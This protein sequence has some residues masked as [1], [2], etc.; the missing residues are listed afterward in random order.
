[1]EPIIEC[2]EVRR[3]FSSRTFTG[4]KRETVALDNL[5]FQVPQ[6]IVFSLLGPN[7]AGKTTTI[8]MLSTLLIPNSGKVTV[9]GFDIVKE[10]SKVRRRIGLIL[11]GERG[12]YGRLNGRENLRYFA[13]LNHLGSKQARKRVDE[14]LDL[15][16]LTSASDRPVE[17]YSRG[18]RQR[19]HVARGLLAD[20]EILFM[21]EPTLG[22]DPMGAQELRLMIPELIHQGKTILLTTHYMSEADDLSD[23]IAIINEEK[24]IASGI[25]SDIKRRFSKIGVQEVILR[26]IGLAAV[27]NLTQIPG[28]ERVTSSYD[29]PIQKLTVHIKPGAE[30]M[31][32]VTAML[33]KDNIESMVTRDPTLEEAY[34]SIFKS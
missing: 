12:L 11:G 25:P 6:G 22:L 27:E 8:K 5:S 20:P 7:G 3:V 32:E 29:G 9:A 24:I 2:S 33:G 23:Q 18:M 17:Q 13:A 26:Q 30:V 14:L 28:I 21:D 10:A 34:L 4:Q 31:E 15:V 1:M 19:L 16:G